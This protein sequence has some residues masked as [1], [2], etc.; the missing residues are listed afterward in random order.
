MKKLILLIAAATICHT[1]VLSQT[2]LCEGVAFTTQEQIDNFQLDYPGCSKIAGDMTICGNGINNLNG[3]SGLTSIEGNLNIGSW[4]YGGNTLLTNLTG[5]NNI[6]FV[7]GDVTIIFNDALTNL[8]GLEGL[9]NTEG[10]LLVGW[11]SF[12]T[13]AGLDGLTY[14]GGDLEIRNNINL[15]SLNGLGSLSST[16]GSLIIDNNAGLTAIAG[17]DQLTS[18]YGD[19]Y[20]G[21]NPLINDLEGFNNLTSVGGDMS[22]YWN[23]NLTCLLGLEGLTSIKSIFIMKNN[24]LKSLE[25][26][27]NLTVVTGSLWIGGI[28]AQSGNNALLNLSGLSKL[29][30][31]GVNL[32]INYN[33]NLTSLS[34]IEQLNSIGGN[35]VI[36]YNNALTGLSGLENLDAASL[37]V[38]DI[39]NNHSLSSCDVES[40]CNYLSSPKGEIIIENNS[41]GCNNEDEVKA[42][43]GLGFVEELPDEELFSVFPNPVSNQ[44][45][46]TFDLTNAAKVK[47][48]IYNIMGRV[49]TTIL[50]RSLSQGNHKVITSVA[51][52]QEGIYLCRLSIENTVLVKK[53]IKN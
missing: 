20:L 35:L 51:N 5:L 27:D 2:C 3:F 11:N 50:D 12:T 7:G 26:L 30:S 42:S 48:E 38:L 44:I 24:A 19:L 22:I 47:L 13:L 9:K 45:T 21:N 23:N 41:I 43:C 49:E 31:I 32:V 1:Y 52:L 17:L 29:N 28:N 34:G 4:D 14:V 16:G 8:T 18:V 36:R 40:I 25:G 10:C 37:K 6:T 53:L 46:I 39:S 15:H 33:V